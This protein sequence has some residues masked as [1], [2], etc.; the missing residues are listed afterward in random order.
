[1]LDYLRKIRN[2][3]LYREP[4]IVTVEESLDEITDELEKSLW[5]LK[6][7]FDFDTEE[8]QIVVNE[9]RDRNRK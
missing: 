8:I 1:M 3:T 2:Y 5:D 6:E 4:A 9:Y 7:P